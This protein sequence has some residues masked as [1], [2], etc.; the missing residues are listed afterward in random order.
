VAGM[1]VQDGS[2]QWKRLSTTIFGGAYLAVASGVANFILDAVQAVAGLYS[3]LGGFF[4]AVVTVLVGG[5]ATA[6]SASWAELEAWI[7][8]AGILSFALAVASVLAI[9]RVAAWGYSN[10]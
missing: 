5:P 9:A 8:S 7:G 3:A 2:I 10:V 6:L 1:F 4:A